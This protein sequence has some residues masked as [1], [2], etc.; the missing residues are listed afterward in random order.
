MTSPKLAV[1]LLQVYINSD[2][3]KIAPISSKPPTNLRPQTIEYRK[4]MTW[5]GKFRSQLETETKL[6]RH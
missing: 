2:D 4:I 5:G 6:G 1:K 3:K